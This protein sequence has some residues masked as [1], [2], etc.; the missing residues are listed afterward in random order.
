[1]KKQALFS[2]HFFRLKS[3][4]KT[5][6][7]ISSLFYMIFNMTCTGG[8]DSVSP[9]F[10]PEGW[11]LLKLETQSSRQ[12]VIADDKL[13]LCAG[14][15]GLFRITHPADA[16][17]DW[18]FLGLNNLGF[19]GVMDVVVLT[20][21]LVVGVFAQGAFPDVAGIYRS[22]DDGTTWTISDHGFDRNKLRNGTGIVGRLTQSKLNPRKLLAGCIGELLVYSSSDF[23]LSWNLL[24]GPMG[25]TKLQAVA[26]NSNDNAL[27]AG[28]IGPNTG[29][30]LL[31][32]SLDTGLTWQELFQQPHDQ[33]LPANEVNDIVFDSVD[34]ATVYVS[35]YRVILKSTDAGDTWVASFD[36]IDTD[37]FL[38]LSGNPVQ[39]G[40]LIACA[41]DSLYLTT[42]AGETWSAFQAKPKGQAFMNN[43]AVDW[44]K[45]ILYVSAYNKADGLM[46]VYQLYF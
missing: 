17:D 29:A 19:G 30:S 6:V 5:L 2:W 33:D 25:E 37:N 13:Y 14:I 15:D 46:R 23:G 10:R 45:K 12:L 22:V 7:K 31:Y 40:E 8:D 27:W 21:T 41:G 44:R 24:L 42:D 11:I 43:M 4:R 35:S 28:G 36:T 20:D 18:E 9:P 32:R 1:M 26:F 34:D 38:N 16:V 39:S 3:K